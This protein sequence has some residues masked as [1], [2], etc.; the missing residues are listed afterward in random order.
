MQIFERLVSCCPNL[1]KTALERKVNRLVSTLTRLGHAT[2]YVAT[3]QTRAGSRSNQQR[4][5]PEHRRSLQF[6]RHVRLHVAIR[7]CVVTHLAAKFWF[8]GSFFPAY[9]TL[10]RKLHKR[11]RIWHEG[12][13]CRWELI[14]ML[15]DEVL[16]R[17][18]PI[19]KSCQVD[20]LFPFLDSVTEI[21]HPILYIFPFNLI[22]RIPCF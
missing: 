6:L 19:T 15:P 2:G 18:E 11:L 14:G 4:A 3:G 16:K 10:G 8:F 17:A 21:F 12:E 9:A 22:C 1:L 7:H 20:N 13:S 5:Q